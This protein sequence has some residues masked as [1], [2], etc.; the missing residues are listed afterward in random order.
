[1]EPP[2]FLQEKPLF[3]GDSLLV[4]E[5]VTEGGY[6]GALRMGALRRLVQLL[7][8][9]NENQIRAGVGNGQDVGQ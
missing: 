3:S 8:V 5:Q 1:M 6:F 4:S 2:S 7:R 9:A